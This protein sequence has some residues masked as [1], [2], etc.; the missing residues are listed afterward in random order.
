MTEGHSLAGDGDRTPLPF[1]AKIA[2]AK[3]GIHVVAPARDRNLATI[4]W[5]RIDFDRLKETLAAWSALHDEAL[6]DPGVNVRRGDRLRARKLAGG[7]GRPRHASARGG[8]LRAERWTYRF[9]FLSLLRHLSD[10]PNVTTGAMYSRHL[11]APELIESRLG[12]L[13]LLHAV[14]AEIQALLDDPTTYEQLVDMTGFIA[15]AALQNVAGNPH[16]RFMWAWFPESLPGAEGPR[17]V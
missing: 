9:L 13:E 8:L 2:I 1:A 3:D 11:T 5:M 7:H 15:Q 17:E 14:P 16:R 10:L 12:E 6:A 4:G